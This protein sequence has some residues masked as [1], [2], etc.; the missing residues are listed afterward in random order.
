MT[1]RAHRTT[2]LLLIPLLLSLSHCKPQD[3]TPPIPRDGS[4]SSSRVTTSSTQAG[5][6]LGCVGLSCDK[7]EC[8]G[9]GCGGATPACIGM[10]CEKDEDHKTES[11]PH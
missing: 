2:L 7:K 8:I 4:S 1:T 10:G 3:S 6:D 11:K 5:K 9:M